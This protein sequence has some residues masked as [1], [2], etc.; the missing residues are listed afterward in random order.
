MF[1]PLFGPAPGPVVLDCGSTLVLL[2]GDVLLV[3]ESVAD[4]LGLGDPVS[5]GE[6]LV[7][8][9]P[10]PLGDTVVLGDGDWLGDG[11]EDGGTSMHRRFTTHS[12]AVQVSP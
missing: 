6:W 11:D 10:D 1:G 5:L 12:S 4:S 9:D 7:L 3:E 2:L 8:G